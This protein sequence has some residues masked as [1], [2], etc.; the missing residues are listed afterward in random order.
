MLTNF[1]FVIDQNSLQLNLIHPARARELLTVGKAAVL[2]FT[3]Q[4]P[5]Q[6]SK[7][8]DKLKALVYIELSNLSNLL[9]KLLPT[10]CIESELY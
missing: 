1:V 4:P 5:V 2:P 3:V 10:L 9:G 7:G 6:P 8:L